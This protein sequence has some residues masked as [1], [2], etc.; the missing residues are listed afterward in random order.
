[1]QDN[2]DEAIS[3][4]NSITVL[5]YG[6]YYEP[7]SDRDLALAKRLDQLLKDVE[8]SKEWYNICGNLKEYVCQM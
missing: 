6:G 3:K 2:F 1:M 4:L 7:K 8:D 5:L